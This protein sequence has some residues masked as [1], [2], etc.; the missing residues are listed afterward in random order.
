[1]LFEL[2]IIF[3]FMVHIKRN[4]YSVNHLHEK[5]GLNGVLVVMQDFLVDLPSAHCVRAFLQKVNQ[6]N[7]LQGNVS[8][9]NVLNF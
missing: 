3:L 1:M 8:Q 2:I 4:K 6:S 7:P 9:E 5:S